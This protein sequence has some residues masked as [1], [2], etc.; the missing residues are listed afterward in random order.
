MFFRI[1]VNLGILLFISKMPFLVIFE[2]F[3]L[4]AIFFKNPVEIFFWGVLLDVLFYSN[5]AKTFIGL[6]TVSGVIIFF[7]SEYIRPKIR[8]Q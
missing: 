1:I 5:D 8:N 4:F 6:F 2:I 7:L 3:V